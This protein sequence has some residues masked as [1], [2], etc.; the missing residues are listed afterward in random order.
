MNQKISLISFPDEPSFFLLLLLIII[1][2]I[3]AV[4]TAVRKTVSELQNCLMAC[5]DMILELA[6]DKLR[7]NPE[8]TPLNS[9][10]H[11]DSAEW[12]KQSPEF[13]SGYFRL[14]KLSCSTKQVSGHVSET[15]V[16][17][18]LWTKWPSG[19]FSYIQTLQGRKLTLS[20]PRWEDGTKIRELLKVRFF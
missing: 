13:C 17:T 16:D 6:W 14:L 4:L 18:K 11:N 9:Q 15:T 20:E 10:R 2:E 1:R 8:L 5:L 7:T 19:V 3:L 12:R